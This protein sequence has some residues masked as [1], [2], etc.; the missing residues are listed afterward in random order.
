[1]SKATGVSY[2]AKAI[3]GSSKIDKSTRDRDHAIDMI[4]KSLAEEITAILAK[5]GEEARHLGYHLYNAYLHDKADLDQIT[6]DEV[7][8][9]LELHDLM[10]IEHDEDPNE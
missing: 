4:R 6:S 1:M 2:I 10:L 3:A 8:D 9:T 7:F 5:Y